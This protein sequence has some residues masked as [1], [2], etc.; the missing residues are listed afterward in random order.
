VKQGILL[1]CYLG[2]RK[3]LGKNSKPSMAND[4]YYDEYGGGGGGSQAIPWG[5]PAA[6]PKHPEVMTIQY[7]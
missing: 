5:H 4:G 2:S 1:Q 7:K 3:L 6:A